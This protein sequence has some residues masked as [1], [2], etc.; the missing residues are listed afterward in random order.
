MTTEQEVKNI[1]GKFKNIFGTVL[2]N[3]APAS[4]Y[5]GET[6]NNRAVLQKLSFP[7]KE[8]YTLVSAEAIRSRL[9][10]MLRDDDLL[11]GKLNRSR[12]INPKVTNPKAKEAEATGEEE[13]DQ[14]TVKFDALPDRDRFA[15]DLLFGFLMIDEKK[16]KEVL[17]KQGDSIL[18][19]NYAVSLEPFPRYN[20]HTMH[21][22]PKAS[23]DSAYRNAKKSALIEREV[24][25]TA[26]QY[27]F[28][29]N[30]ND[31]RHLPGWDSFPEENK[32]EKK[33][34]IALLLRAIGE[35]NGV[36]GNHARTMYPF[37]PVSIVL[38]LTTRRA[39]EFDIYG[40]RPK[41][42]NKP[43]ESQQELIQML[44]E[45]L[46][47]P[48]DF[49]LGGRIVREHPALRAALAKKKGETSHTADDAQDLGQLTE[50]HLFE[51]SDAAI[52]AV[53]AE[54]KLDAA[55]TNS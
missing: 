30:L 33:R 16:K 6:Q 42:D 34:W 1:E 28:G 27:P 40:F 48:T 43:D 2:T 13:K 44:K 55:R 49:Y 14:I 37:A 54:A 38:R 4:N 17:E 51:T 25:V 36:G 19:V 7:N 3:V 53:I 29:L 15:D 12:V 23:E 35:L 32:Q 52:E 21:Q 9:R 5:R 8:Q 24:H 47:P 26:F 11:K 20:T 45:G 46:L 39:P 31:L 18:R 22:S 41:Q 10:E 50:V